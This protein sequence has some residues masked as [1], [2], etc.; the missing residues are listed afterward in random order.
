M[1]AFSKQDLEI[2]NTGTPHALAKTA[3][4]T[5]FPVRLIYLPAIEEQSDNMKSKKYISSK[6][7]QLLSLINVGIELKPPRL[8]FY[9]AEP[10][11]VSRR[12]QLATGSKAG[13]T[14]RRLHLVREPR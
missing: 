5:S 14:L 4:I 11:S 2:K 12:E 6:F 9:A 3:A 8:Q 7:Y 13:R 10:P 1:L